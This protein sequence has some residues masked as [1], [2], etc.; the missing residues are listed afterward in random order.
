MDACERPTWMQRRRGSSGTIAYPDVVLRARGYRRY[1]TD[2]VSQEAA[3]KPARRGVW[4]GAFVEPSSRRAVEPSSRRAV[5]LA[6]WRRGA[7]LDATAASGAGD[8][9]IKGNISR[10]GTRV[11][12]VPGGASYAKTR[13]DTAQGERW[14]CTESEARTAGWRRAKR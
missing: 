8:C 14:F 5:A 3:A 6:R 11:Y 1:S 12:H 7:R 2:Y 10:N 4:R 13:I 9:R